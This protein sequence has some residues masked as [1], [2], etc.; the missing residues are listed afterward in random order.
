MSL[1]L[2]HR[3]IEAYNRRDAAALR[4]LL[5]DDVAF[6]RPGGRVLPGP[7]E[8]VAS[9]EREWSRVARSRVDVRRAWEVED[10]VCAEITVTVLVGRAEHAVEG[11]VFHRWRDGRLVRYRLYLDPLPDLGGAAW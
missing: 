9:Y 8:V 3:Y 10:R 5:A 1:D 4:A 11:S 7:D 6:V 2:T